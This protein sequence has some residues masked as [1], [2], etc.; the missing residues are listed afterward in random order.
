MISKAYLSPERG[1]QVYYVKMFLAAIQLFILK[2]DDQ[3]K[4]IEVPANKNSN[5]IYTGKP[6]TYTITRFT[7][8]ENIYEL[9]SVRLFLKVDLEP[10]KI[11]YLGDVISTYERGKMLSWHAKDQRLEYNYDDFSHKF[12]TSNPLSCNKLIGAPILLEKSEISK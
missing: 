5:F 1:G 9:V 12:T 7:Y 10:G 11:K 8:G 3:N 4:E 2:P 6:G